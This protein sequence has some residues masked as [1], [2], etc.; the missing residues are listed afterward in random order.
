[1]YTVGQV[2]KILGVS[3]DTL[4]FY[5]EKGLINPKQDKDNGYRKYSIED[6]NEIMTINF[7][8]DIDIEIKKIQQIQNSDD[9]NNIE[10]ILNEK[11]NT[12]EEEIKYKELLLKRVKSIKED[13][14]SIK[15]YLNKFTI[16]EM[17]PILVTNEINMKEGLIETYNEILKKYT[18]STRIKE[19]VNLSGISRIVYFNNQEIVKEKYIFYERVKKNTNGNE[20]K[21]LIYYPECLYVVIAVPV[22]NQE[23]DIDGKMRIAILK[24]ANKLG[25]KTMGLAFINILM[26]GYKNK[27]NFLYLEIYT[28]VRK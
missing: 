13:C 1:M 27:S 22:E 10:C 18:Y 3:R 26:N 25:Y 11:Q 5:E 7:Y 9:V 23:D 16:K 4:K 17:K 20:K 24:E 15:K 6:I 2:A 8:R 28:P 21:E 12:L 14:K 19:P